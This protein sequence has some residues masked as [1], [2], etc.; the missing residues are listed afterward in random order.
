[1]VVNEPA[2]VS[3]AQ[4]LTDKGTNRK[5]FLEGEVDK[6][7]WQ[8]TGS[9]FGLSDLLAG[10]LLGQLEQREKSLA[11][12]KRLFDA[13]MDGLTPLVRSA[14]ISLPK[15]PPD[16]EPAYHMFYLLL[17]TPASRN[18][19]LK[20]LRERGINATFHFVPLHSSVG[21]EKYGVRSTELPVTDDVSQRLIRLPFHNALTDQDVD[22]VVSELT[23]VLST[24]T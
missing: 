14:G 3:R 21:G 12:R 17:A 10:Y 6:Y 7:T 18:R 5:A 15:V 13:Y 4:V 22:R 11:K 23:D 8:D 2:D 16:C 9:S 20:E 24:T 1:L 19:A